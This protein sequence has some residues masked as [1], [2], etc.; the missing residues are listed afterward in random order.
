MTAATEQQRTKIKAEMGRILESSAFR[1][2]PRCRQFL[3]FVVENALEGRHESLKERII[4]VEVFGRKPS[5]LTEADSVVR[6]RATE[7]RK[8]LSQYY[9]VEP[10]TGECR[11]EIPSGSYV[12]Q[13]R[14]VDTTAPAEPADPAQAL[15][16]QPPQPLL[17]PPPRVAGW[18]AAVVLLTGVVT[19]LLF[20]AF[21]SPEKRP[22]EAAADHDEK[23]LERFWGPAIAD[24]KSVLICI[25]SPM[26]YTYTH[27]WHKED[28][29]QSGIDPGVALAWKIE[30]QKGQTPGG[31]IVTVK[32][33]YVGAGDANLAVL[34]SALFSRFGKATEF[35]LSDE[36]SYGEISDAPTV[37]IGG[38]SNRWTI[39]STNKLPFVFAEHNSIREIDEQEGQHRRWALP[40]LHSDGKT[41]EDFA[42]VSRLPDSETGKF[43]IIAAG[44]SGFGSRAAGYFLTRPEL[45]AKALDQAPADWPKKNMQFVLK[46]KIVDDAPTAPEIIAW[47]V[48]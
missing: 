14:M 25:G 13:F 47:K 6:V 35:R 17:H 28:A 41:N 43:L 38:F 10:H 30:P 39:S 34:L 48:W 27:A 2:S 26:T 36:T 22:V 9:A 18:L 44:I 5:Y 23:Q 19:I 37:L 3:Q 4:G 16:D 45:L 20:A 15:A 7:V 11:I 12:P 24:S 46:T 29:K 42:I 40:Q 31:A 32:N 21:R 8:R 1:S 33:Q